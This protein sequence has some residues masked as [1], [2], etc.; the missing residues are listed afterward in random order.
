[1]E[2]ALVL[3]YLSQKQPYPYPKWQS[4]WLK[5]KHPRGEIIVSLC[6]LIQTP[7]F[8]GKWTGHIVSLYDGHT[9]QKPATIE[10]KQTWTK[11]CI[12]FTNETS[13]S[14]SISASLLTETG[15]GIVLSYEY[16][17]EPDYNSAS[18]MQIHKGRFYSFG[19]YT[20]QQFRRR[21]LYRSGKV[22]FRNTGH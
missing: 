16:Q 8:N 20:S 7:D 19:P 21:I 4:T 9:E 11:I 3:P 13:R 18:T 12:I 17:N 10:I 22:K 6:D 5:L 14:K 1:I 15:E 2:A